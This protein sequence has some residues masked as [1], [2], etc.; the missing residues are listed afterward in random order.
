MATDLSAKRLELL[1]NLI[2]GISH[3]A[4][5]WDSSNP[6]MALRVRETQLAAEQLKISFYD[7]GARDLDGLEASFGGAVRTT[8]RSVSGDRRS[9]YEPP[10]RS[11][12]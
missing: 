2:P 5:L 3:V 10:S 9:V 1:K 4:V 11:D 7:A 6:G 12:S 8:T